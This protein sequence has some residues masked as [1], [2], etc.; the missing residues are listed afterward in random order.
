MVKAATLC[1][2]YAVKYKEKYPD[3][4]DIQRIY[5][6]VLLMLHS[7][8]CYYCF[9]FQVQKQYLS[10]SAMHILHLNMLAEDRY[11]KIV[12][13]P[14]ELIDALYMDERII[15]K[16]NSVVLNFPGIRSTSAQQFICNERLSSF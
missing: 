8:F 3:A 14:N 16:L 15:K 2:K 6:K 9:I 4:M 11:L 10:Y 12:S 5:I 1:Y 13:D 7:R